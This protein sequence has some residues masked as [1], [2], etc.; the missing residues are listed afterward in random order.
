MS[1]Q[2][3]AVAIVISATLVAITLILQP[4]I[5]RWL[6]LKQQLLKIQAVADCGKISQV[7]WQDTAN[8]AEVTEPYA[9]AYEKCLKD[10][11]Y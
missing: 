4:K 3:V 7:K 10:K 6:D 8:N 11:G 1:E 5:N 9:V 2:N